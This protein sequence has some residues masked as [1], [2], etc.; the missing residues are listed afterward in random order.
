MPYMALCLTSHPNTTI[1]CKQRDVVLPVQLYC[2][3]VVNIGIVVKCEDIY[4]N[5]NSNIS[6]SNEPST[7]A[8]QVF[9][10]PTESK[11]IPNCVRDESQGKTFYDV[12]PETL[13]VI[14]V[15]LFILLLITIIL[16]LGKL[17]LGQCFMKLKKAFCGKTRSRYTSVPTNGTN[18]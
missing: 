13:I 1:I 12:V 15:V 4:S 7:K 8:A 6:V 2:E 14:V 16:V 11:I 3:E 18:K 10:K 5:D 9:S 17:L